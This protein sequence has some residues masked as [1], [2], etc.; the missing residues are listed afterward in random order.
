MTVT[1]IRPLDKKRSRL[2]ID[3]CASFALYQGELRRYGIREG[4]ELAQKTYEEILEVLGKRAKLRSMNLL[5]RADQTEAGLR[6]KLKEGFYPQEC[7]EE[8]V[9]YV[10]SYHYIDDER[11]ARQYLEIYG[12]RKSKKQLRQELQQKG[13]S[14]ELLEQAFE[15]VRPDETSALELLA[16]KR[17]RGKN[18]EDPGEYQKQL[19]YLL[20]KGYHYEQAAGQL[21]ALRDGGEEPLF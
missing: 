10:R 6:R 1:E 12:K 13:I 21:K 2:W 9:A 8:A 11:Y 3:G 16:R 19:R 14:R 5:K 20:S 7:I 17:C 15:E 18:L 4:E